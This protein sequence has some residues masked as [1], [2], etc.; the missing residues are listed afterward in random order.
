MTTTE[1]LTADS[2]L[3]P[4]TRTLLARLRATNDPM[5]IPRVLVT[6]IS[7][8]GADRADPDLP[9]DV[10]CET[11]LQLQWLELPNYLEEAMAQQSDEAIVNFLL[12]KILLRANGRLT[13][14][15]DVGLAKRLHEILGED[16]DARVSALLDRMAANLTLVTKQNR[17]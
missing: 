16:A 3:F 17:H 7:D 4:S 2:E 6:L 13:E 11:M 8:I 12:A 9:G 14:D 10:V 5:L 15:Q 1:Q